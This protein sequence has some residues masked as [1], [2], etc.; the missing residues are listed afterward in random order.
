MKR[1]WKFEVGTNVLFV[2]KSGLRSEPEPGSPGSVRAEEVGVGGWGRRLG[3]PLLA[4][5]GQTKHF[6]TIR[7]KT[8][9]Y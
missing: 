4:A 2:H 3:S 6:T 7:T 9:N 8:W 1:K 5:E